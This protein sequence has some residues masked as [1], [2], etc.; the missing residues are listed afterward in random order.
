MFENASILI[1]G[2]LGPLEI[3]FEGRSLKKWNGERLPEG[4]IY[5]SDKND[6][7]ALTNDEEI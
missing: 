3:G 1:T 4:F 6:G 2:R 7:A 5:R